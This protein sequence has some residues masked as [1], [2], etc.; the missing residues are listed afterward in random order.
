[1]TSIPTEDTD[2]S[3]EKTDAP[4]KN[5]SICTKP[6]NWTAWILGVLLVGSLAVNA[7]TLYRGIDMHSDIW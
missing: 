4:I 7:L 5:T 3:T 2:V 1:M 6:C